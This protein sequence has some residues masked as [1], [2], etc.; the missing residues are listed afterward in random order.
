MTGR[1]QVLYRVRSDAA[2]IAARADAIAVEQSVEMPVSAIDNAYVL[3][4]TLGQVVDI[5]DRGDGSF[6][7]GISLAGSTTGLEAGQ[8][9]N[10]LFGN[11]SI[12]DDVTLIDADFPDD[13]VSAFTGPNQGLEGLR[14]RVRVQGALTCT[15]LKPQGSTPEMLAEI[16][17]QVAKGGI[18]YIKDDHGLADQ[19]YSPFSERVPRIAEAVEK[20][21][22]DARTRY[23]PSLNGNLDSLRRQISLCRKCGLD[24]VL[25]APLIAGVAQFTT[26]VRENPDIAFMAHPTM[27]G[28]SR[29]MPSFLLGKLFRMFGADATIFPNYGGRFSYAPEECKKLSAHALKPWNG[30]KSCTPVPAGGMTLARVPELLQFYGKDVMLLIG[31][32]LLATGERIA[33]ETARYVETV[34]A[35]A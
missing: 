33:E 32:S 13:V 11:T 35:H 22:G 20:S 21:R 18:D 9:L 26:L 31:G 5:A 19:A 12:Q 16:A 34:R 10:M 15:A 17:G 7:V 3:E 1:I 29:I 8:L 6:D 23:L 14:A 30:I 25:I 24:T 2:S 27:A 28:A 4:E